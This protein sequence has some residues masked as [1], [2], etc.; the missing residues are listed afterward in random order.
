MEKRSVI[1]IMGVPGSGKSE[2]I[3]YLMAAYRIPKFSFRSVLEEEIRK[4]KIPIG[5]FGSLEIRGQLEKKLGE[6]YFP[7]RITQLINE[8]VNHENALVEGLELGVWLDYEILRNKFGERLRV[9]F[10][11]LPI[12]NIFREFLHDLR[13]VIRLEKGGPLV[14]SDHLVVNNGDFTKLMNTIDSIMLGYG[15]Y[16]P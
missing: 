9:I 2:V 8:D 12:R 6:E 7:E 10:V 11:H 14:T 13:Q 16:K 15:L 5:Y 1:V 3:Q 4:A